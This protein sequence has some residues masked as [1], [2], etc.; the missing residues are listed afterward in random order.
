MG[1]K[2]I[3]SIRFFFLFP[4]PTSTHRKT[5]QQQDYTIARQHQCS[6]LRTVLIS[7]TSFP[8]VKRVPFAYFPTKRQ[9]STNQSLIYEIWV[10]FSVTARFETEAGPCKS[11]FSHRES[12]IMPLTSFTGNVITGSRKARIT[13]FGWVA[14]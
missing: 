12:S 4:P 9:D 5:T 2:C 13:F 6:S 7:A 11:V 10:I 14:T 8:L 1:I 3:A